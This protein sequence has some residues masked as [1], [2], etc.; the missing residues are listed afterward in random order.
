MS[1]TDK[2]H[3]L[4]WIGNA[5]TMGLV[6]TL[7]DV[8]DCGPFDGSRGAYAQVNDSNGRCVFQGYDVDRWLAGYGVAYDALGGAA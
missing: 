5:E 1:H 7:W 6:L 2:A 8:T 3:A 4:A